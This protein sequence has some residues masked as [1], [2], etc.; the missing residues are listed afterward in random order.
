MVLS[1]IL[2]KDGIYSAA[3]PKSILISSIC[4][5][6]DEIKEGTLFIC[7][8][9]ARFSPLAHLEE[10]AARGAAAI[11][12]AEANASSME[13]PLPCFYAA[14]L[15]RAEA[16]I[17]KRF[18]ENT[19]TRVTLF[20]VTGTN[21]KTSTAMILAHLFHSAGI[22]SGYM[23]TLGVY[24]NDEE[25]PTS[26]GGL[27]TPSAAS[28]YQRIE[29]LV[30]RG[31][32][33]IVLEAS[34]HAIA[35]GRIAG[36]SFDSVLFTN[37][38]EDHLDYHG[39]MEAYFAAKK[40]IF[41]QAK[42][43]IINA[44]DDYG[45]R[46][47]EELPIPCKSIAAIA[48]HADYSVDELHE[49]G[50]ESTQYLCR[51]PFGTFAV[52]YPLF[53]AFNVYNTLLAIATAVEAGLCP[54]EIQRAL[55]TVKRPKGRLERLPLSKPFSVII[56]YAHTPDAVKGALKAVRRVAKGRL[57]ALFGAGGEREREKRPKM[58][59]IAVTLSDMVILTS[60][61]PRGEAPSAIFS[62]LLSGIGAHENYIL[63]PNRADAIRYALGI[64]KENDVLLLLGKGHEE[65]LL[66]GE[67]KRD[68]S[69]RAI[70]YCYFKERES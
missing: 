3:D 15:L 43:A 51:A 4:D 2:P 50:T 5:R 10:I 47:L 34:S 11:L 16:E 64:L 7:H 54:D 6:I 18:Y 40:T 37:L 29:T 48:D 17:L 69:E 8:I 65:Y 13:A 41:I 70:V 25:L 24:L 26:N 60:D 33:H 28:V 12:M 19:L 27:T 52:E 63:I 38:T 21:G 31:A 49:S 9:G 14:D 20:A 42:K 35:Q 57:L 62:D 59:E 67:E 39:T 23:G 68:F 44:D 45:A 55:R 22:P 56:D 66:V 1:S 61:N 30:K 36:L 46:L 32:T 58:A 53:G